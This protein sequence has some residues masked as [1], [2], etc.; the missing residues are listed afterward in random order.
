MDTEEIN[1]STPSKEATIAAAGTASQRD[2]QANI[3]AAKRSAGSLHGRNRKSS[4]ERPSRHNQVN[5][6]TLVSQE[7]PEGQRHGAVVIFDGKLETHNVTHVPLRS[8]SDDEVG[9]ALLLRAIGKTARASGAVR[10]LATSPYVERLAALRESGSPAGWNR[11]SA[12]NATS[13]KDW[14]GIALLLPQFH[15]FVVLPWS[16]WPTP[17]RLTAEA[18][19]RDLDERAGAVASLRPLAHQPLQALLPFD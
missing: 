13:T 15:E 7:G 1:S 8:G 6:L 2:R 12:D 5:L 3:G 9:T 14:I 19:G 16:D 18:I 17:V 4:P 11:W 10:I